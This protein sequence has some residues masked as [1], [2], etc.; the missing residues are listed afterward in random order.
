M[1]S[2]HEKADKVGSVIMRNYEAVLAAVRIRSALGG[3]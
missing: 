2:A 1:A 3:K